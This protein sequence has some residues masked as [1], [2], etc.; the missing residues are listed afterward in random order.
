M[1]LN[2]F[3]K[4]LQKKEKKF[5][6]NFIKQAEITQTAAKA[7]LELVNCREYEEQKIIGRQIKKCE[8]EGDVIQD[9]LYKDLYESFITPFD[10]D[11][12]HELASTMDDFLDFINDSAKRILIYHPSKI[13]HHIVEITEC[14]FEDAHALV[15]ITRDL[16]FAD[17]R[18]FDI[19]EQCNRI[20]DLEHR[21]DDIFEDYMSYL[22]KSESNAIEI[23]KCKNILQGVEDTTD[24]AKNISDLIRTIIVKLA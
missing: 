20:K 19:L 3:I 4:R 22:F 24:K 15:A 16:E 17:K 18:H 5:Y 8:T 7:L 13:D 10:R 21:A 2:S 14:I 1:G 23:I 9:S 12:M 11:D 6:P